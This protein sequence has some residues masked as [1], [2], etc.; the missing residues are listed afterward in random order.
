MMMF[1]QVNTDR[2]LDIR[3]AITID[4]YQP[5]HTAGHDSSYMSEFL[6]AH[7]AAYTHTAGPYY[8]SYMIHSPALH[9]TEPHSQRSIRGDGTLGLV[10]PIPTD[11]LA[12][13]SNIKSVR[14][15][16]LAPLLPPLLLLG[17]IPHILALLS[18]LVL[19]LV[20]DALGLVLE[21]VAGADSAAG[22]S[23][24]RLGL[25]ADLVALRV[26]DI[27]GRL[28]GE[29]LIVSYTQRGSGTI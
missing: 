22:L 26:G 27:G 18:R 29:E 13:R 9:L 1:T 21:L 2:D 17:G 7:N 25:G 4:W 10:M 24:G 20:G 6:N 16:A 15:P 28:V 11:A 5:E 12:P 8:L 3:R 23:R 19:G 14:P